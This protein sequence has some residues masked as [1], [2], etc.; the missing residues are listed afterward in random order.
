MQKTVWLTLTGRQRGEDGTE[1]VTE[2]RTQ[3][4][5]TERDGGLR[6]L[7]EETDEETGAVTR[8]VLKWQNSVLELTKQGAVSAH[9]IFEA[10]AEHR[11]EYVTPY[12]RLQM[13]VRTD[14][15]EAVSRNGVPAE[16][17]IRYTLCSDGCP[18]AENALTVSMG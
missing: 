12:G 13:D 4:E 1:T 18:F 10:G 5:Y 3:A 15:V 2:T 11:T 9:I 14:A 6:L 7:Y 17:R 16:I 8:N